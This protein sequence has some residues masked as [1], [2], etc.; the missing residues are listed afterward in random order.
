MLPQL[1]TPDAV[2]R[3]ML[4]GA[5]APISMAQCAYL[6]GDKMVQAFLRWDE[7][8]GDLK[9]TS[10]VLVDY[11]GKHVWE[12][13]QKAVEQIEWLRRELKISQY[14][15]NAALTVDAQ[16]E[17]ELTALRQRLRRARECME[18]NDPINAR[19]IFGKQS[20]GDGNEQN[21][22]QTAGAASAK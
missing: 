2:Q 15:E 12:Q 6:H 19:K 13:A 11:A 22:R 16:N 18:A 20:E 21:A 7:L 17:A 10:D 9:I 5:I 4:S 8:R 3:A 14:N 1:E